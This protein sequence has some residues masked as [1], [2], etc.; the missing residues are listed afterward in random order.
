MRERPLLCSHRLPPEELLVRSF[1][2]SPTPRIGQATWTCFADRCRA[3]LAF[4]RLKS[5]SSARM[6]RSRGLSWKR[7]P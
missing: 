4:I 5:E 1:S 2:E 7:R 3:G 6:A